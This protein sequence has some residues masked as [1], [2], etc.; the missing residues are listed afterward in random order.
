MEMIALVDVLFAAA[1]MLAILL[2][3]GFGVRG[4]RRYFSERPTSHMGRIARKA[5]AGVFL[6][7]IV[8]GLAGALRPDDHTDERAT[9]TNEAHPSATVV[10]KQA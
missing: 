3:L 1:Q 4:I 9:Q 7:A 2:V 6:V 10:V 8:G 5:I